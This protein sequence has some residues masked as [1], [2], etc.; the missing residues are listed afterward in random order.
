MRVALVATTVVVG[1]AGCG[2]DSRPTAD[3]ARGEG[4]AATHRQVAQ[5]YRADRQWARTHLLGVSGREA[6][7]A[8]NARGLDFRV[9]ERDGRSLFRRSDRRLTRV[10]VEIRSAAVTRVAGLF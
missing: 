7:A 6:R 2:A 4:P 1:C 10:N 3:T 5:T 8:A 9:L